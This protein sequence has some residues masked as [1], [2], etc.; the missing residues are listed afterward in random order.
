MSTGYRKARATLNTCNHDGFNLLGAMR[1]QIRDI[2]VRVGA[3]CSVATTLS[4]PA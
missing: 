2:A 3:R 1:W 4:V